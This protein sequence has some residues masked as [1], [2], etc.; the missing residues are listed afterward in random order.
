MK[1][2]R[3]SLTLTRVSQAE[4]RVIA[5][6]KVAGPVGDIQTNST[7][8]RVYFIHSENQVGV[9]DGETNRVIR[10][11]KVGDGA[12]FLAVNSRN[13]RIYA[14]NFRDATVSVIS[15]KTNRVLT[16]VPV[17]QRPFGIGTHRGSNRIYA[18][19]LSGT[20]SVI[21]GSS[22]NVIQT[23]RVG[24]AP[25]LVSIN[26]RTNFVYVTNVN[27]DS[28]HIIDGKT[29]QVISS[30]KV[31][32]NPIIKP[33]INTVTNRIYA[34]NNLSRFASLIRGG[35]LGKS[36]PIQLGR[37]QSE[38][39]VNSMTNRIYITSAQQEGSGKLFIL[40]GHTNK[41][42]KTIQIP[43]FATILVNP[44][45]NHYF[46]GDSDGRNLLVYSGRTNTRLITLRTGK[47]AGN[48]AINFQKNRIYVGN[49]SSITVVQ[50]HL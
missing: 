22:N 35:T 28:V 32:R 25:A 7:T 3:A 30:I 10:N 1:P 46:I 9:L 33:A 2:E 15:G 47:S 24:G 12:T 14:T 50:D 20:I 37:R 38:I 4:P 43:T 49:S 29:L 42:I 18:A 6:V 19:N 36:I 31:G 41:I 8:G 21:D 48:M 27:K 39:A 26:E 5:I 16:A 40:N 34:A 17:G 45:T 44:L 11:V 23:L 13:N